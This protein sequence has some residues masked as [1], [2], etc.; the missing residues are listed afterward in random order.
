MLLRMIREGS[1]IEIRDRGSLVSC[2]H[3]TDSFSQSTAAR[4]V[5]GYFPL[6]SKSVIKSCC[7]GTLREEANSFSP[8]GS[9]SYNAVS[10]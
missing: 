3:F 10:V 9:S 5:G 8:Q 4:D 6:A 7:S 2:A 1:S